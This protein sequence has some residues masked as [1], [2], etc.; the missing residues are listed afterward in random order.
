M[1]AF[2]KLIPLKDYLYGAAILALLVAFGAFTLHERQV[3]M[4]KIEAADAKVAAAAIA[5]DK[6]V[7]AAAQSASNNIGLIY[8]K[9]VAIPPVASLGVV[10]H[11]PSGGVVPKT[12]Q[13]GSGTSG[14][15]P[16]VGGGPA[17]DPSGPALTVGRNDDALILA[18]QNE[19]KTLMT[20]MA[21]SP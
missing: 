15:A 11:A 2:L 16:V 3:G 13:G 18:L 5:R 19:V 4:N 17:F 14:A 6:A 1:F 20:E 10:C 8:E 7:E 9:A 21:G 12:P